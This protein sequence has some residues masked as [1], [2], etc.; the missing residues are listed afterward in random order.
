MTTLSLTSLLILYSQSTRF[1]TRVSPY[2]IQLHET[3]NIY[4]KTLKS[5]TIKPLTLYKC[6]L[7]TNIK[8]QSEE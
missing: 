4:I 2:L 6:N 5:E 7:K 1:Q 3:N 8:E